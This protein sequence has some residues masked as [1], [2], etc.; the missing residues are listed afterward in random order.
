MKYLTVDG[1]LSGTGIRNS[2]EGGYIDPRALGISRDLVSRIEGWLRLY[3][4]AH[5]DGFS[6]SD[7]GGRA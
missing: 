7:F 1:L 6:D 5:F 3:E 2:I 4:E